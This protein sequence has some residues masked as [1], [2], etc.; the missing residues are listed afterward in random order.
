MSPKKLRSNLSLGTSLLKK[1]KMLEKRL[2]QAYNVPPSYKPSRFGTKNQIMT[3]E[4]EKALPAMYATDGIPLE[5]KTAYAKYF[6]PTSNWTWIAFEYDPKTRDIFGGVQSPNTYGQW[7][8]GY[9][10]LDQL[11]NA[12]HK[13]GFPLVERDV[14][15]TPKKVK[16]IKKGIDYFV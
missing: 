12:R 3:R 11:A 1:Q 16:D 10:N 4:I 5:E 13:L 2:S 15:F 6:T 8:L 9:T 14:S 7:E